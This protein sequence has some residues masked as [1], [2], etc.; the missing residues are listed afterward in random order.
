MISE[1][2]AES[3][4]ASYRWILPAAAAFLF[5]A[6]ALHRTTADP[7]LFGYLN[8]G[9]LFWGGGGFPRHD[10]FSYLP[11]APEWIYHEWLFGVLLQPVYGA[12]GGAALQ[13]FRW[14]AAAGAL[15]L[16]LAVAR[17][18]GATR[19]RMAVGLILASV[20]F[21]IGFGPVRAQVLTY[22][23][24]ALTLYFLDRFA[25][26]GRGRRLAVLVP[27]FAFWANCH[28][29]FV[30]GLALIGLHAAAAALS[31]TRVRPLLLLLAAA[32]LASLINPYG[33]DY[34]GY[35][36]RALFMP[37]P[38]IGEWLSVWDAARLGLYL[39]ASLLFVIC[40][41]IALLRAP[42]MRPRDPAALLVLSATA[43]E[44][45]LHHRHI[46]FFALAFLAYVPP[47]LLVRRAD[48]LLAALGVGWST[49]LFAGWCV[50]APP[51]GPPWRLA[52]P[53]TSAAPPGALGYPESAALEILR[54]AP[55]GRPVRVLTELHWG[56]YL[57]YRFYP[58]I[59]VGV[60]G[61]YETVFPTGILNEYLDFERAGPGFGR[62]LD[63]YPADAVLAAAGSPVD[64]RMARLPGWTA[65]YR[66]QGSAAYV[67]A[68]GPPP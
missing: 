34:W 55:L 13:A 29:G 28:G 2:R 24:F 59:L 52:A 66:D 18:R 12:L 54:R 51:Q 49:A 22:L 20:P 27:V 64:R 25:R 6:A 58:R 43:L 39:D 4:S 60:D 23:F 15:F 10:V 21:A 9:G 26:D 8:F 31:R 50:A 57:S 47:L 37:R 16:C 41:A 68:G 19:F 33:F 42:G 30:A 45:F 14:A 1:P 38:G 3:A 62:F 7:D 35:L 63:R 36:A 56:E 11:T 67:R 46:V 44:G 61:R 53:D 48:R 17:R 40:A 32:S 65:V 5:S